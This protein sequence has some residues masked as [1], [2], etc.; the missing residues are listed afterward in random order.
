VNDDFD[1]GD[2]VDDVVGRENTKD[3]TQ[4]PKGKKKKKKKKKKK[5]LKFSLFFNIIF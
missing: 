2:E 1:D 4:L 5:L 3:S